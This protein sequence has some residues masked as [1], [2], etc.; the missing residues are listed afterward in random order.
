VSKYVK[1]LSGIF[2]GHSY[3]LKF[4]AQAQALSK[5]QKSL[6]RA[7]KELQ[8]SYKRAAKEVQKSVKRA[9]KER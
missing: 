9:L 3:G 8:K 4:L 6:K 2:L 1:I 7:S 5:L